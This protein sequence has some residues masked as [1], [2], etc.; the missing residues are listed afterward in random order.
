MIASFLFII[1]DKFIIVESFGWLET[2]LFLLCVVLFIWSMINLY[3]LLKIFKV[4]KIILIVISIVFI[5]WFSMLS[6][7]YKRHRNLFE[8]LFN[9]V[10]RVT[11][12]YDMNIQTGQVYKNKSTFYLF[13]IKI[14]EV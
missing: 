14:N 1:I 4:F 3:P 6:I 8:P 13:G 11:E 7:D 10:Y 12:G 9:I 5:L 2:I